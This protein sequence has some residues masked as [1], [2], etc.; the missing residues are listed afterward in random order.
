M[1]VVLYPRVS[2]KAQLEGDS[3]DAQVLR[4]TNF[5]NSKGYEI[6]GT[7]TDAGKSASI[8]EDS[9]T[10]NVSELYFT[11]S[12]KLSKRPGFK[13]LLQ[14]A[15][16]KKFDAIICYRWDR[17]SRDISFADL[18]VRYFKSYGIKIIPTDDSEDPF[19]SSIMQVVNKQEIDKMKARVRQTRLYRFEQGIMTGRSPFGY[20]PIIKDKKI[21]GFKPNPKQAEIV[22]TA[23]K[24]TTEGVDYKTICKQLKLAPQSYYN[25]IRNKVYAGVVIFEGIERNGCHEALI[26]LEDYN[27]VNSKS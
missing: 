1:K 7:Y 4:L 18:S 9:I 19:V 16:E 20:Q 26:S 2:S 15:K 27:K 14:E 17:F 13:R 8:D 22:K 3:I 12:F 21:I 11:N 24:L 6:I 5:C 10:Q 23:F 25:I